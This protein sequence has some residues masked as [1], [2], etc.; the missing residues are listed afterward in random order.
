MASSRP[1]KILFYAIN[2]SGVGHLTRL[3]AIAREL[4]D[5]LKSMDRAFEIWFLTTSEAPQIAHEFPV[6]KLPSKTIL[7]QSEG[8]QW[9]YASVAKLMISNLI[10]SFRPDALIL[11]TIP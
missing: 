3:V 8:G 6:F 11:D 9:A 1:V 2:G 10:A 5:L 7:R 4:R